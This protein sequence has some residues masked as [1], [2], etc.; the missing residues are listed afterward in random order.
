MDLPNDSERDSYEDNEQ[1]AT[2][3]DFTTTTSHVVSSEFIAHHEYLVDLLFAA[4]VRFRHGYIGSAD[5]DVVEQIEHELDE[6]YDT[7]FALKTNDE[8]IAYFKV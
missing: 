5:K 4:Y 8:L 1:R 7:H 3:A 2:V 6:Q